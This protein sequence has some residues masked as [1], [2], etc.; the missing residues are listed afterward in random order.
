MFHNIIIFYGEGLLAPCPSPKLE[1]HPLSVVRDCLFNVFAAT[2]HTW[3][4]FLLPQPEDA[5]CRGDRDP[6]NMN[7][8]L[9]FALIVNCDGATVV[10]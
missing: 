4:P 2:L 8:N 6:L 9:L 5:P 1:D 10:L 7:I 3:R